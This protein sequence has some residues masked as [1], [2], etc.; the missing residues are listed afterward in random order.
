M[1][2]IANPTFKR[3]L[4]SDIASIEIDIKDECGSAIPFR[5][6]RSMIHLVIRR[7]V[8]KS[9]DLAFHPSHH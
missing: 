6:G 5:F 9:P 4:A 2:R 1:I 7:K 3:L 8:I